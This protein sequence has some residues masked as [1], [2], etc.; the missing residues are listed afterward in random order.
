M[1]K[2]KGTRDFTQGPIFFPML[3][4]TLPIMATGLLQLLYNTADK[5]VV[6]QFAENGTVALGAIGST[7]S[8]TSLIL[9]LA[10]GLSMGA[11][12]VVAKRFGAHEERELSRAVHTSF[13]VGAAV[14]L[15]VGVVGF[16]LS[17][18]VLKM[19]GT[20][21]NL[22]DSAVLY[23]RI[24]CIGMPASVLYNFGASILRSVGNSKVPLIILALSGL[25]NVGFNVLF[26]RAFHMSVEGVAIATIISQYASAVAVWVVLALRR[27]AVRFR[28]SALRLDRRMLLEIIRIGVPSA[29]Q[30]ALFGIANV[31][32]QSSVNGLDTAFA[33]THPGDKSYEGLIVAGNTIG[34][35]MEGYTYVAM[36]SYYQA[37]LTFTGQNVGAHKPERVRKTLFYG[38]V[39]VMIAGLLVSYGCL[40]FSDASLFPNG[41]I[42]SLFIKSGQAH[43]PE[44]L[45]AA[46]DRNAIVLTTYVICGLMEVLTGHLRGRGCS[47]TPMIS[48]LVCSCLMRLLW[49]WF[50]FP[51]APTLGFLFLCYPISW[52]LTNLCHI[53]TS[54]VLTHREKKRMAR[55]ALLE[56]E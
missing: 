24:I 8:L 49:V 1:T 6:G 32:L 42:L 50:V 38:L 55:Q 11:G 54:A 3:F 48:S 18:P 31:L 28:F 52:I 47:I 41:G 16:A 51:L 44:V 10:L 26:V 34:S 46:R 12:V 9:A 21:P 36:N 43:I 19:M 27:D 5:I 7:G 20:A 14:G 39:Q 45:D 22:H 56:S 4:F 35:D 2:A 33:A 53:A 30:S 23:L 17:H 15:L 40:L 29:L 25:L 13:L 37:V